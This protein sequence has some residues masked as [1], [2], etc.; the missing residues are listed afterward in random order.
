MSD[1]RRAIFSA[2]RGNSIRSGA[3]EPRGSWLTGSDA[4]PC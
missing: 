3:L 1:A 2:Q 4:T